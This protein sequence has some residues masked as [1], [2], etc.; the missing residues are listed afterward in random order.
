MNRYFI[1]YVAW[2]FF[3]FFMFVYQMNIWLLLCNTLCV[4][5]DDYIKRNT[6]SCREGGG[7]RGC[8]SLWIGRKEK[9]L[10]CFESSPKY[11]IGSD[12][13]S[14]ALVALHTYNF[15]SIINIHNSNV[16]GVSGGTPYRF[17]CSRRATRHSKRVKRA[18][19]R[20]H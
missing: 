12:D 7:E 4:L 9:K 10:E 5:T 13:S 17:S 20:R 6:G 15:F 16:G 1:F 3:F 19:L 2:Y 8:Y 18:R 14:A 11:Y